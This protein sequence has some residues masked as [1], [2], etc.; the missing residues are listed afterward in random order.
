M[1]KTKLYKYLGR[2]GNIV[3]PILLEK[4]EPIPMVKIVADAG[5]ILT[6]G[7]E[8]AKIKTLFLDELEE[9]YET[10]DPLVKKD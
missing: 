4:I 9:W 8:Y 6:N 3:T 7:K 1:I 5:K 10:N 2:N